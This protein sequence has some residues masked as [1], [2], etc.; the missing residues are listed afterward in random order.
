M[1]AA[2][3]RDGFEL[4]LLEERHAKP[5]FRLV[6][7]ERAQLS[8]WLSWVDA[9]RSEEDTGTFVHSVL[10]QFASNRGFA[11]GIWNH[12]RLTG[13]IGTHRIDWLNRK[14][15]LGYWLAR[16]FQGQGI[17]TDACRA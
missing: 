13:T 6:E 4:R 11:A 15:E 5:L 12:E 2:P 3:I 1:F 10:E 14:V 7:Q 16:G 17:M 9:T 8:P